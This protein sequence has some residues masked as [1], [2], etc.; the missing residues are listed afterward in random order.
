MLEKNVMQIIQ[1]NGKFTQFSKEE[2]VA[3]NYVTCNLLNDMQV[4]LLLS[5]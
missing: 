5:Y 1:I 3:D 2:I 4:K